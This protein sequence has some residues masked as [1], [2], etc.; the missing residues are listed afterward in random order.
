[1][2]GLSSG[3]AQV[4]GGQY[5]TCAVTTD[6]GVKCWGWNFA[7]QVGDG[8]LVDAWTPVD[9]SGLTSGVTQVATGGDHTCALTTSGG[10]KCWGAQL[11]RPAR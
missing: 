5:H 10:V 7:G 2:T 11:Q 8:T 4:R 3:V 1:V 6:G 9:V